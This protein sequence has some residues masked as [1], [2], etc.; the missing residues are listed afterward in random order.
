MHTRKACK[1][2]WNSTIKPS[3]NANPRL[4]L[5]TQYCSLAFTSTAL[6]SYHFS[7]FSNSLSWDSYM[8]H[9]AKALSFNLIE[10]SQGWWWAAFP[11]VKLTNKP[12][13]AIA[14]KIG[15]LKCLQKAKSLKIYIVYCFQTGCKD[16]KN[17]WIAQPLT[18]PSQPRQGVPPPAK[19]LS[20]GRQ[21]YN[22][23]QYW[24]SSTDLMK[25][26]FP[27]LITKHWL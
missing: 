8:M 17:N 16:K 25:T 10:I 4:L 24:M 11:K 1:K 20:C 18:S 21:C 13:K 2:P 22:R 7:R 27:S 23:Y 19:R 6:A 9:F 3:N 5:T 12:I 14:I 26:T 15:F